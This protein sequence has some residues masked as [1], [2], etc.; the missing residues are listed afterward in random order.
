MSD[1]KQAAGALGS[2]VVVVPL[3]EPYLSAKV[4]TSLLGPVES[5]VMQH[6][7]GPW[8]FALFE[9]EPNEAFVQWRAGFA[10]VHGSRAGRE[11]NARLI[12]A[13]PDL[14]AALELTR[15]QWIHSKNAP[16]CLAA[17]ANARGCAA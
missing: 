14:L 6:T 1:E 11:T 17:I 8:K 13:A 12:A 15:G 4:T 3:P 10:A 16:A 9:H 5:S 2:N 7:P